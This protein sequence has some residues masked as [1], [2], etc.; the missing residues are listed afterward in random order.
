MIDEIIENIDNFIHLNSIRDIFNGEFCCKH[1]FYYNFFLVSIK[2]ETKR[3]CDTK[4]N[5]TISDSDEKLEF[6]FEY[7]LNTVIEYTYRLF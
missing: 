6:G 1:Y 7:T 3:E 4:I 5:I 2:T